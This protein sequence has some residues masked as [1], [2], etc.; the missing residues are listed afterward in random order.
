M[1]DEE[2]RRD[3]N[4][5]NEI[6]KLPKDIVLWGGTGQAKVLK[7]IIEYYNS[8]VCIVIDDTPGL[9]SPFSDV[10]IKQGEQGFLEW[11]D[12]RNKDNRN[13]EESGNKEEIGFLVAIGNSKLSRNARAR[14]RISEFLEKQGLKPVGIVHQ[15]AFIDKNVRIGKGIQVLA[16][17][18]IMYETKI[19]DYCIINTG[20]SVDHECVLENGVEI[21]PGAVLC[22]CVHVG[23][24]SWIGANATI[25]PRIKI[26][27][28]SVVGAGSVATGD[29]PDNVIVAGNPARV[30][31]KTE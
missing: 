13:K 25:L 14:I 12:N 15:T 8:K 3:A 26:G 21:A 28:N 6:N 4:R 31:K 29:V 17:A 11:I 27:K 20:A 23:E 10:P 30:L 1:F 24:N 2:N 19:G 7:P 18:K 5:V 16:G 9:E 22:G